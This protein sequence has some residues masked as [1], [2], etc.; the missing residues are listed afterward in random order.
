MIRVTKSKYE[1]KGKLAIHFGRKPEHTVRHLSYPEAMKL[2]HDL[3]Q[4]LVMR[5]LEGL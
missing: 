2:A 3:Q 4:R 1:P 5:A